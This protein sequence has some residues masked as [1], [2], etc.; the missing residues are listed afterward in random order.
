M[1]FTFVPY[2]GVDITPSML[3]KHWV[4]RRPPDFRIPKP[5]CGRRRGKSRPRSNMG[6]I[7]FGQPE[8][9]GGVAL[10][11]EHSVTA[12]R[13]NDSRCRPTLI[14]IE[15]VTKLCAH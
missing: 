5:E 6:L 10:E 11:A 13:N 4:R 2:V 14:K 9:I 3:L 8:M 15:T 7:P 12:V 1:A